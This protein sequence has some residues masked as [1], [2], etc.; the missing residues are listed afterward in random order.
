MVW[1]TARLLARGLIGSTVMNW[2]VRALSVVDTRRGLR[3]RGRLYLAQRTRGDQ[4]EFWSAAEASHPFD[5]IITRSKIHA[6]LS[7]ARVLDAERGLRRL[8]A[9]R[10][11]LV[12]DCSFVIGLTHA[13]QRHGD[14]AHIRTRIRAFLASLHGRPDYRIAAVR[15]H[16]FIWAHFSRVTSSVHGLELARTRSEAM[17]RHAPLRRRPREMLTRVFAS[18]AGLQRTLPSCLLDTDISGAQ[19]R[20]FIALVH[21]RLSQQQ[22][23]SFVR[24]GDGEAACLPYEPRLRA[25]AR[26]DAR[27]RERIW[28]GAPL[29]DAVRNRLAPRIARAIWDADCIGIPTAARFLRELRLTRNDALELSLTGRGLRAI[30]YCVE[31]WHE[32]RSQILPAP[33]FASSH[34][35]QD[36]WLWDCYGELFDGAGGVSLVSCHVGLPDWFQQ[37]FGAKV[38]GNL[39]L[40][41]D[42]VSGPFMPEWSPG[43]QQLPEM[44][45]DILD[46]IGNLPRGQLVLVGAGYPGKLLVDAASKRGCVALDL[47]SIFDYWMGLNT[48]SYLDLSTV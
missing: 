14:F 11:S 7:S 44:L 20:A 18:E 46:K 41:P 38:F 21:Q 26:A 32:M 15:L 47:G 29:S 36:L 6:A 1:R 9:A 8:T 37:N 2:I 42:R 34:L 28:W 12:A 19:C 45:D 4:F 33:M 48:R 17:V 22:A 30:L 27:A 16:R 10:V 24:M 23:F 39:L 40:P 13:D 31:R 25:L 3:W 5:P 43:R 35:H